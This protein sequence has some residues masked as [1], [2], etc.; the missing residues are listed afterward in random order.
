VPS[1]PH[2]RAVVQSAQVGYNK[3]RRSAA[4]VVRWP[5][6]ERS[7]PKVAPGEADDM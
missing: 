1:E 3:G 6:P 7:Y 5:Q 2:W 4:R